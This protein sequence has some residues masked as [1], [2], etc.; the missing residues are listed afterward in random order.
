MTTEWHGAALTPLTG[1]YSG[2]TFLVG[3]DPDEQ[4]V[5]RIYRRDPGRALVDASLLRLVRGLLPVPD[6]LEERP[7]TDTSPAILVTRKLDG[8]TLESLLRAN[9]PDLDWDTLGQHLGY[10]LAR[11]SGIPFLRPGRFDGPDLTVES[12]S[13]PDDLR[14]FTQVRRDTG[15][16]AAWQER[17]YHALLDLVDHA[18]DV[19]AAA[20]TE[21]E[22]RTVLVHSDFNPKNILVDPEAAEVVG[23]VDWEFAYAGSPYADFGNLSRFEREDK[24]TGAVL[25]AFVDVGSGLRDV[26]ERSR[27]ADLWAL[28]ELAGRVQTNPVTELATA[29]LLAQARAADLHAWPWD[30]PRVDPKQAKRVL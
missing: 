27:A 3:E 13:M 2:E 4:V 8:V 14:E 16:L 9:P 28:V 25:E 20:A 30:T 29:L 23:V 12:T 11:L 1:G 18:E 10:L 6:V 19:S 7:A 22:G 21:S 5:L 24:L 26:E 15:R 17:D